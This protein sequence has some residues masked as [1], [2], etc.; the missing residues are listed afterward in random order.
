MNGLKVTRTGIVVR[1]RD[2]WVYGTVKKR[3]PVWDATSS[4]TGDTM[5][6]IRT[7]LE[8]VTHLVM[9][10]GHDPQDYGLVN[11]AGSPA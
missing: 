7:R 1:K 11:E 8:A 2:G 3:G 5:L 6:A 10:N 9:E 4:H